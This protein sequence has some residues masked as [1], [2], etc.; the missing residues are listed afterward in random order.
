MFKSFKPRKLATKSRNNYKS[1]NITVHN[2][3]N[4][5]CSECGY[6][7]GI[8]YNNDCPT[9]RLDLESAV[10]NLAKV[11]PY[12]ALKKLTQREKDIRAFRKFLYDNDALEAWYKNRKNHMW[13]K[14]GSVFDP[15]SKE[16]FIIGAFVWYETP[17]GENYWTKLNEKW[18]RML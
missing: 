7:Y 14:K 2:D 11:I 5:L 10:K 18:K 6:P 15:L 9:D 3:F 8:H 13:R 16:R 17:E 4:E 12:H 1:T